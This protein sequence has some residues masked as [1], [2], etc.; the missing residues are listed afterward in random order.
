MQNF[1]V[2]QKLN[3]GMKDFFEKKSE[4]FEE[5]IEKKK[6]YLSS[7]NLME[8]QFQENVFDVVINIVMIK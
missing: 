6:E 1:I 2:E 7:M 4:I 5:E 3:K 8:S